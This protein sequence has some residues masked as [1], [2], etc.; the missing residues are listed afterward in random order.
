MNRWVGGSGGDGA[1][2]KPI[3]AVP[4][5]DQRTVND[6]IVA[7]IDEITREDPHGDVLVF[8]PGEREIQSCIGYW[9]SV[10][11]VRR[12]CCR[13]TRGCRLAIKIRCSTRLW[14]SPGADDQ[15]C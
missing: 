6:A 4:Q 11:I 9:S 14:A 1:L 10:S 7:V 5:E 2:S 15:R 3:V 8:L 12:N 13:Y